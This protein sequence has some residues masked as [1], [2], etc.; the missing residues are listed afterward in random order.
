MSQN[1]FVGTW[2]Y[3]S[4]RNEPTLYEDWN[5][6]KFGDGELVIDD[7]PIGQMSGHLTFLPDY[8]FRL[9]GYC[10]LGNPFT[11]RFQGVGDARDSDGQKYDYLG[12]LSPLWP[13]GVDQRLAIVGTIVRTRRPDNPTLEGYVASWIAVQRD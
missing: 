4:F 13:N 8:S 9:Q 5:Q 7:T 12:Y 11:I 6:L 3:R 10:T 1:P 2:T